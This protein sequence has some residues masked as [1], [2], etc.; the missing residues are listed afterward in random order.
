M[1]QPER[2]YVMVAAGPGDARH[3]TEEAREAVEGADVVFGAP[4][5]IARARR[6]PAS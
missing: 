3:L 1:A 2:E 4:S 5:V 6:R